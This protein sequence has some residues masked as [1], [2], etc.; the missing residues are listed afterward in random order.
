MKAPLPEKLHDGT[1]DY[2]LVRPEAVREDGFT[3]IALY[4]RVPQDPDYQFTPSL[5]Y[6]ES[7]TQV[8]QMHPIRR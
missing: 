7:L 2:L 8:P 4:E 5:E 6:H 1:Y 3:D